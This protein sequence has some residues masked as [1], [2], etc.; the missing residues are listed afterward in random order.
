[1]NGRQEARNEIFAIITA[2]NVTVYT[3]ALIPGGKS[4]RI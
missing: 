3:K 2:S 4:D 1:M